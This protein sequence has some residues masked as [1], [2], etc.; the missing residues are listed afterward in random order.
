[1]WA[2]LYDD[3]G[4]TTW[5][6]GTTYM[7]GVEVSR[8]GGTWKTATNYYWPDGKLTF[9]AYAPS[10]VNGTVDGE[11][12][13]FPDYSVADAATDQI[14]L[15]YSERAY[16]KQALDDETAGS[17]ITD[18][19]PDFTDDS[20][21][22]VH[23]AFK[24]ALSSIVF[25]VRT[26]EDYKTANGATITLTG[27]SISNIGKTSTF[28]QGITDGNLATSAAEWDEP[29]TKTTTYVAYYGLKEI[30]TTRYWTST[31]AYNTDKHTAPSGGYR[32][33]DFILLPQTLATAELNVSYEIQY[34]GV[35][36]PV[37]MNKAVDL[38]DVNVP[39]WEMGKR[40]I[41][42]IIISIGTNAIT[43]EPYVTDWVDINPEAD[44]TIS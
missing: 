29:S 25:S 7:N 11:G 42:N 26:K 17:E 8:N 5:A 13:H 18:E 27:L 36:A 24:H 14:D 35:G 38:T 33:T 43:F 9:I 3:N 2:N 20:Y 12:V 10:S 30:T 34:E 16:D 41:Y 4:Y 32:D 1:M 21:T 28:N 15:L 6:A 31:D 23:L 44:I 37:E 40:Y 22:G 19:N 39:E